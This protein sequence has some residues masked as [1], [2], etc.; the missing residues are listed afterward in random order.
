VYVGALLGLLPV[1]T[2]EHAVETQ[3]TPLRKYCRP[4]TIQNVGL[5]RTYILEISRHVYH[6]DAC[7]EFSTG[8]VNPRPTRFCPALF[9][10]TEDMGRK[11][12]ER[13]RFTIHVDRGQ[14]LEIHGRASGIQALCTRQMSRHVCI[15]VQVWEIHNLRVHVTLFYP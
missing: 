6:K 2:P 5:F 9:R 12:S 13:C 8:A 11:S 1:R 10:T 3:K 4:L 15:L 14:L 7:T